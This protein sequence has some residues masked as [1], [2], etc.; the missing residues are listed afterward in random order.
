VNGT[1]CARQPDVKQPARLL[2]LL[3]RASMAAWDG[4]LLHADHDDGLKLQSFRTVER[5]EVDLIRT[6]ALVAKCLDRVLRELSA[7]LA[8]FKQLF[9]NLLFVAEA[10]LLFQD[11]LDAGLVRSRKPISQ[12][13]RAIPMRK[14]EGD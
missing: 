14:Q 11:V 8:C 9:K 2:D 12:R 4:S 5:H 7:G 6:S 1:H 3:R 13:N 10:W